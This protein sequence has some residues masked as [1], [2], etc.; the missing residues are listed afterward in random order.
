MSLLSENKTKNSSKCFRPAE[1][2]QVLQPQKASSRDHSA[3]PTSDI[4]AR[5]TPWWCRRV[6]RGLCMRPAAGSRS[7]GWPPSAGC[8]R[9][10]G[11][12]ARRSSWTASASSLPP[13]DN[14]A[15]SSTSVRLGGTY[16]A[17]PPLSDDILCRNER[18]VSDRQS[19]TVSVQLPY[20]SSYLKK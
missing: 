11:P 5:R 13:D 9:T 3:A 6:L 7:G 12:A 19:M 16:W 14:L 17:V 4:R 10:T 8:T 15:G 2:T 20:E 18:P 1:F